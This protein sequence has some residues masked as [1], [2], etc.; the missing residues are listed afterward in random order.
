[1]AEIIRRYNTVEFDLT[2]GSRGD[3]GAAVERFLVELTGA[4]ASLVVNNN[5]AAMLLALQTLCQNEEVIVSRGE[6]VEIGGAFRI[7]EVL[8][9]SGAT[10]RDCLLYTSRCV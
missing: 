1:M 2:S 6:L 10:L 9:T 4:Q 3:R 7:P 8:E 5:A